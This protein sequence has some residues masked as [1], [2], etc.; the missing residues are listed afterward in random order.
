MFKKDNYSR[1]TKRAGLTGT[2]WLIVLFLLAIQ[3]NGCKKAETQSSSAKTSVKTVSKTT[4]GAK[5]AAKSTSKTSAGTNTPDQSTNSDDGEQM[6][7]DENNDPEENN[8]ENSNSENII[9]MNGRVI[10][11]NITADLSDIIKEGGLYAGENSERYHS[12]RNVENKYNCKFEFKCETT[13]NP[14]Y[15][16]NFISS[17]SA[18]IK[19]TDVIR[20]P[21]NLM[22]PQ[23]IVKNLITPIDEFVDCNDPLWGG[24]ATFNLAKWRG[25]FYGLGW[26]PN[27]GK[28]WVVHYNRDLFAREA[29]PD[30]QD[31]ADKMQ[32][33]WE[34]FLNIAINS[35][36]DLNGDGV[37]DQWGVVGNYWEVYA[38]FLGSNNGRMIKDENGK[39]KPAIDTIEAL[40]SLDFVRSMYNIH[41]IAGKN[42]KDYLNGNALMWIYG[43]L[44][45]TFFGDLNGG[46]APMP[47]GPN[48]SEY[49]TYNNRSIP[50]TFPS[51]VEDIG[52]V[53]R[54]FKEA[55][56]VWDPKKEMH[57]DLQK[58]V[59]D[60]AN[61]FGRTDRDREWVVKLMNNQNMVY[62]FGF[63]FSDYLNIINSKIVIPVTN[64]SI[65]PAT[66][67][68][69][70]LNAAQAAIDSVMGQ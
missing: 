23:Y 44:G 52:A 8:N 19:M 54:V 36:R 10:L 42:Y 22:F 7:N 49:I 41:N 39:I 9:D 18:G 37:I 30:P 27:G 1:K 4:S 58:L 29:M 68:D 14:V 46:I 61:P 50:W 60:D 26:G 64:G 32:W 45:I 48:A 35:T 24:E 70:N 20:L 56:E 53:V 3:M 69:T 6:G 13:N 16:Q 33:E 25:R 38:A 62:D 31:L 63:S 2:M 12:I 5:T 66:A 17:F 51:N 40:T 55:W 28:G 59:W 34:D 21:T 43:P 11:V 15:S 67:I 65:T 47:I 57:I